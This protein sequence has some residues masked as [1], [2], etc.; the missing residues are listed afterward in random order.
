MNEQGEVVR[1]KTRLIYKGYS[2]KEGVDYD[3]TYAPVE[4][5]EA[6]RL[7][8]TYATYKKFKVY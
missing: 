4:R 1:E 5:I 7:F 3:E 2:Q 8:L 6:V